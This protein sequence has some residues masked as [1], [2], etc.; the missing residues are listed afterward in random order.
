MIVILD[1]IHQW[2][3]GN[4]SIQ[5][6]CAAESKL[7]MIEIQG[8]S[9]ANKLLAGNVERKTLNLIAWF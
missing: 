3:M 4:G 8:S 6:A 2:K 9:S 7:K 1:Y 5:K